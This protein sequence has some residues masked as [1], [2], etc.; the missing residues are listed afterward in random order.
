MTKVQCLPLFFIATEQTKFS[1]EIMLKI[2]SDCTSELPFFS[3]RS[4]FQSADILVNG[5][6]KEK[7]SICKEDRTVFLA[8][9]RVQC[10]DD[11]MLQY[12]CAV[13]RSAF[14]CK[15]NAIIY[16][17]HLT[18]GATKATNFQGGIL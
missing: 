1:S 6:T 5:I 12:I 18:E 2:T 8:T 13:F 4:E 15:S 9:S 7:V 10:N 14:K 3:F 11:S 16:H 17:E